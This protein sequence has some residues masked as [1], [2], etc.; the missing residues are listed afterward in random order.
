VGE[1]IVKS[2]LSQAATDYCLWSVVYRKLTYPLAS[3]TITEEQCLEILKPLLAAGLPAMGIMQN[4]PQ[5]VIHK[6]YT[7]QGMQ[8][9]NLHME[10]MVQQITTLLAHYN[11]TDEPIGALLN[12]NCESLRMK[13]GWMGNIFDIPEA[14]NIMIT[15]SWI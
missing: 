6:L 11:N 7:K 9:P 14:C 12:A 10:Q 2:R 8:F 3:M 15:K 4:F 1:E 5:A 13:M